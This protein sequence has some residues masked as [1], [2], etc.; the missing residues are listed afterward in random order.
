MVYELIRC[1][2]NQSAVYI[3]LEY[4]R[5]YSLRYQ[6]SNCADKIVIINTSLPLDIDS[7]E[8]EIRYFEIEMSDGL[9]KKNSET[10]DL[11][12]AILVIDKTEKSLVVCETYHAFMHHDHG[13]Y[14]AIDE[15]EILTTKS[16]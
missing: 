12:V 4:N 6:K 5:I 9:L 15:Q 7:M 3:D 10:V 14:N 13:F 11:P 2:I 8:D 16:N 1:I